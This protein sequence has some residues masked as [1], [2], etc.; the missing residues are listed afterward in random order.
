MRRAEIPD[1]RETGAT[2]RP[3]ASPYLLRLSSFPHASEGF[4]CEAERY[5]ADLHFIAKRGRAPPGSPP[6]PFEG[7]RRRSGFNAQRG[8]DVTHVSIEDGFP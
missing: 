2:A 5:A 7:R 6:N 4:S 1:F 3:A 8:E